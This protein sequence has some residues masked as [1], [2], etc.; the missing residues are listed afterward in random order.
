MLAA[1]VLLY[2]LIKR[3]A[4]PLGS[5]SPPLSQTSEVGQF[6]LS[7]LQLLHYTYTKGF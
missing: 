4:Q 5:E 7:L 2:G 3:R 6:L 1:T